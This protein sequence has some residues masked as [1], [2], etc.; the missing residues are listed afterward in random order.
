MIKTDCH[1]HTIYS[2][3]GKNTMAEMVERA[4]LFGLTDIAVTD[5]ADLHPVYEAKFHADFNEVKREADGLKKLYSDRINII[6]GVEVGLGMIYK[7][8]I[9]ALLD[10]C[11]FEFVIGSAHDL[12]FEDIY[13]KEFYLKHDKR[14]A[15]EKFYKHTLECIKSTKGVDVLGHIDYI[16]RYVK[17]YGG[18]DGS[19]CYDDH[20]ELLDEIFRYIIGEGIGIEINTSGFKYGL[21]HVHPDSRF[22]KRYKQLGGEIVTIGSDA[23]DI[24]QIGAHF[25]R[26]ESALREAGF[27]AHTIWRD[28]RA[29]M[30]DL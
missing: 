29:V 6:F 20:S 10:S 5:H 16:E 22:V 19:F 26:A 23:H 2:F 27:T 18:Y 15:Y 21:G 30:V 8:K 4:V 1:T 12:D 3:D 7:S 17:Q 11:E 14:A 25:E 28:G 9:D 13:S 24:T